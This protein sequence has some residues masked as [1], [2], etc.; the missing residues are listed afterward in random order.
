MK[1][2]GTQYASGEGTSF[3]VGSQIVLVRW[4]E[5]RDEMKEKL[6]PV[7]CEEQLGPLSQTRLQKYDALS[8]HVLTSSLRR[9]NRLPSRE[10]KPRITERQKDGWTTVLA[11]PPELTQGKNDLI[12][13]TN[14]ECSP[15]SPVPGSLKCFTQA[16][17]ASA[18]REKG[19][20]ETPHD[21]GT[22]TEPKK[23][24]T[25]PFLGSNYR[26]SLYRGTATIGAA[27]AVRVQ[28]WDKII[29]NGDVEQSLKDPIV[30]PQSRFKEECWSGRNKSGIILV[31]NVRVFVVVCCLSHIN[32]SATN[33]AVVTR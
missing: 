9:V 32:W 28:K 29:H 17:R 5:R 23:T 19:E 33:P 20:R 21:E 31:T 22:G 10:G 27:A 7:T 8:T 1:R 18:L 15:G 13:R 12:N 11:A 30:R 14:F 16:L 6:A 26:S 3:K 25:I 4:M 2:R 24:Y